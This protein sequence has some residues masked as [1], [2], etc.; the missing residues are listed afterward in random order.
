MGKGARGFS[1]VEDQNILDLESVWGM[2]DGSIAGVFIIFN[3]R[4]RLH[5]TEM[6]W[7]SRILFNYQGYHLD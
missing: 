7:Q 1:E 2:I 4:Y 3:G 5:L 6:A